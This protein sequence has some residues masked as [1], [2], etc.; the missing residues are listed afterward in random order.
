M[1]VV[2]RGRLTFTYALSRDTNKDQPNMKS[3]PSIHAQDKQRIERLELELEEVKA[4]Y[5]K[6]HARVVELEAKQAAHQ[7]GKHQF[8]RRD[9][10]FTSANSS[11]RATPLSPMPSYKRPTAASL[12]RKSSEADRTTSP[13]F[14]VHSAT[15][16]G[17]DYYYVD[18]RITKRERTRAYLVFT[19]NYFTLIYRL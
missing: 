13:S 18:G 10:A 4:K 5:A 11:S 12:N 2:L 9:S 3:I 8:R 15:I 16:Q 6:A 14:P 19:I 7:C 1:P 17:T